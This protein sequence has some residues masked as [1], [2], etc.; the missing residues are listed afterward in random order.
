MSDGV[1]G[2]PEPPTR[3]AGGSIGFARPDL[4]FSPVRVFGNVG[5]VAVTRGEF[6]ERGFHAGDFVGILGVAVLVGLLVGI[7]FEV[8]EFPFAE[9]IEMQQLEAAV[10]N[11]KVG[12]CQS[13]FWPLCW[14]PLRWLC[15]PVSM[16]ARTGPQIELVQ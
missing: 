16:T 15:L 9:T 6:V 2:A 14:K 13:N 1:Q 4:S 5:V 12:W 10:T 11:G 3:E 8:A 7:G